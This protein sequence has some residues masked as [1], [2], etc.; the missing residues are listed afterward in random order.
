M[1]LLTSSILSLLLVAISSFETIDSNAMEARVIIHGLQGDL[2]PQDVQLVHDTISALATTTT[3]SKVPP[4]KPALRANAASVSDYVDEAVTDTIML[5]APRPAP[6]PVR[7]STYCNGW[8]CGGYDKNNPTHKRGRWYGF[9]ND[10][11]CGPLC[12]NDDRFLSE[13]IVASA[14]MVSTI[15]IAMLNVEQEDDVCDT[16]RQQGSPALS[17]AFNCT[18]TPMVAGPSVAALCVNGA[19]VGEALV[20]LDGA[21]TNSSGD[22]NDEDVDRSFFTDEEAEVL[23]TSVIDAYN[24]AFKEVG[25][26]L[27]A[28]H[29]LNMAVPP[30]ED[31]ESDIDESS[32]V[33]MGEFREM[34]TDI[35]L[36]DKT[37]E[38][39]V[40]H[41][42]LETKLCDKLRDS[43]MSIFQGV[44]GCKYR[45]FHTRESKKSMIRTSGAVA[46]E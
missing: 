40:M 41:Q 31:K 15:P 22:A 12:H 14:L 35:D 4:P 29:A 33:V 27:K 24:E 30:V 17:H 43:G 32:T 38:L 9:G 18:I 34:C 37:E 5:K 10:Y 16:L 19:K 26:V 25:L 39:I 8:G 6:A 13:T 42:V 45:T 36:H 3:V 11:S 20:F 2:T 7:P 46:N 21:A 1:N 28:F 23:E 44:S